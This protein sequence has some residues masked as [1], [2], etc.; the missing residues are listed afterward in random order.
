MGK[1]ERFDEVLQECVRRLDAGEDIESVLASYPHS[2]ADLRPHLLVW[3]ALSSKEK[4]EATAGGATRGRQ[5]L[6][7]ALRA[8]GPAD[9]GLRAML[10]LGSTGRYL[11]FFAAGAAAALAIT[12]LA[13]SLDS[14]SS[15]HTA[16]A[17]TIQQCV[18]LLDFNHDG[19]LGVDDVAAFKDA[20]K[21][22]NLA[23]DFNHDGV[24]DIFDVVY[25]VQQIESCIQSIIPTPPVPTPT[26]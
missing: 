17:T 3:A 23:F 14:G 13:G 8:P 6:M 22:Q 2:E 1:Q 24:V 5:Q 16:Q 25:T 4:S 9:G 21:T 7:A 18:L 11:A 26:P 15:T 19:T 10:R 12:F 20:I